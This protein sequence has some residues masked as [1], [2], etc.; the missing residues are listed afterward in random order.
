[1]KGLMQNQPLLLSSLLRYAERFHADTEIVSRIAEGPIHRETYEDAARRARKLADALG[2]FGIRAGDRVG[3][4]AW[5]DHR[6]FEIEHAVTGM[7]AVWHAI[8]PRLIP[9]QISY[10]ADHAADKVLFVESAF[11]PMIE[12][13]AGELLTVGLFVILA[14]GVSTPSTTLPN[15]RGYEDFLADGDE[16]FAWPL[17]DELSASS[18]FYTSGTTGNPKGVLYSH[19]SDVLHC[20]SIA[21]AASGAFTALDTILPMTPMF[22]ANGAWGFTHAAPMVGAKLV[23]PG[24]KMDAASIAELIESEAVT[25]TGGVPVLYARLLQHFEAA[26]RG[27]G[28]LRR[29]V[30]AGS[31]PAPS[32]IEGYERMG[33][34]VKHVWGMT[35]TSPTGTCPAPSRKTARLPRAAQWRRKTGQGHPMY[36]VDVKIADENGNEM[37]RDGVSSGRLMVRGP[38]IASGYFR[39][40]R[41]LLEDGW[42]NTGD[43]AVMDEDNH[44]RLTDR[45]K[46]VIKS[47]GEWISSI[48]IENLVAGCPGV[49]DAAVIGIP[50]PQWEE[51][52]L[53]VVVPTVTDPA[54]A[55]S[56]R[57]F[58]VGRIAKWWMPDDIVFVDA[59]AYGATGKVQ[60]MEL[61]RHY[62]KH[63]AASVGISP[64]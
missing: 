46:D 9:A 1:M 56:I 24:P 63:Y 2:K 20:L 31:A 10:I 33:V 38:W 6:H 13:L 36:G 54:S 62:A 39:D 58:L 57:A 32:M 27:A 28:S 14:D 48:D 18:L 55:K 42:F 5:N 21:G 53:L 45:A 47:G 49:A 29:I 15:V 43:L 40:D 61:R 34:S 35:E 7:G 3:T 17:F 51:R 64:D 4:L 19:R 25:V 16:D 60:K 8:N 44:I 41:P 59:L 37:P 23:L 30:V 22:H 12:R 11:V 26:G 50:H 52:P